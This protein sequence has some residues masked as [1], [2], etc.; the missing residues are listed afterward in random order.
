MVQDGQKSLETFDDL[1]GIQM[2]SQCPADGES[3]GSDHDFVS[4]TCIAALLI[5][6]EEPI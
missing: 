2:S 3:K 6:M 5:S 1:E 4:R